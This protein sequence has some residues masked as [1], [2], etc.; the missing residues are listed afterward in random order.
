MQETYYENEEI[1][2]QKLSNI[3]LEHV[4]FI[5]CDFINCSFEELKMTS[6]FF[7]NCRFDHCNIIRLSTHYC[8]VKNAT[9]DGCNLI[10]IHW[11][12]MLP[13]GKYAYPIRSIRQCYLKY[14]TFLDMNFVKFD[15]T[16]N[17]IQESLFEKCNLAESNFKECR[18][19]GTQ[20]S[21]CDLRKG[22]FRDALGYSIDVKTN[23]LKGSKFSF[24]E[25]INLLNSLDLVID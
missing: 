11:N 19:E 21:R 25:V 7:T 8:E 13:A 4:Y 12:E 14:H 10:G 5:D 18:L 1:K 15:F 2:D 16:S 3:S 20:F 22:D 24:P 23:Q 17:V 6:C 9:F